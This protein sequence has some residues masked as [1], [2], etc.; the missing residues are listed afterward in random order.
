MIYPQYPAVYA[1]HKV[2]HAITL[3]GTFFVVISK[4]QKLERAS[5]CLFYLWFCRVVGGGKGVEFQRPLPSFSHHNQ[6]L[7]RTPCCREVL[8]RLVYRQWLCSHE[9]VWGKSEALT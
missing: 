1:A 9:N 3:D 7:H 8:V 2:R 6:P 4:Q 5:F